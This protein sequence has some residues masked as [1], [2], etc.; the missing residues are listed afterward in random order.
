MKHNFKAFLIASLTV[1]GFPI[2]AEDFSD[3][4][5]VRMIVGVAAGGAT[6]V[7]ARIIA[8]KMTQ[9]LGTTVIVENK[10]GAFFEP[11][12]REVVNAP[13]DGRTIFMI[14]ASTTVTQPGRK[15]FAYDI[16]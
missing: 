10:T 7:T 5:P 12:Y 4:K 13:P 8:Q 6:D 11:A 2:H 15:D 16:R 1:T 3:G 14:S 9:T